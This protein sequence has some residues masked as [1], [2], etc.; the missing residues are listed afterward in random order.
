MV[1]LVETFDEVR[2]SYQAETRERR[3]EADVQKWLGHSHCLRE[4]SY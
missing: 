3:N 4:L 1:T 2:A